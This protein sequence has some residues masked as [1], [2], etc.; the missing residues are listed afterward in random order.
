MV[1]SMVEVK[2]EDRSEMSSGRNTMEEEVSN[3]PEYA[4]FQ[5]D[6]ELRD[7]RRNADAKS[8][9]VSESK[10]TSR[11]ML[12]RLIFHEEKGMMQ[13]RDTRGIEAKTMWREETMTRDSEGNSI[14]VSFVVKDDLVTPTLL[15]RI[16][17]QRW[18]LF[19][20]YLLLCPI[21]NPQSKRSY[22]PYTSDYPRQPDQ[23]LV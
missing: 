7:S 23:K 13:M 14:H 1:G 3:R 19:S 2:Q 12:L 6:G 5:V 17:Q 21:E 16:W 15:R 11:L 20:L 10:C 18:L 8:K 22:C 9:S 4:K